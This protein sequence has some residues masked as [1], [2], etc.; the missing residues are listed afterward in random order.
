[1]SWLDTL[2]DIRKKD[3]S[4]S[5][6]ADRDKAARD[7]VNMASYGC[8]VVAVSPIPFSD[9]VLSLPMQSAMVMTVGHVYGRKV[10]QADAKDLILEL[11]AVAGMGMLARQG[12]KALLPVV[13]ALLTVP[14]AYAMNW[15]I[16][17][18]AME[19]FRSPEMPKEQLK[20]VY[21]AARDEGAKMFSKERF[22]A[23]RNSKQSQV[24]PADVG[25]DEAATQRPSSAKVSAAEKIVTQDFAA[26]LEKHP[27]VREAFA[28]LIHLDLSGE[29][30]GQWTVDLTKAEGFIS[31][32]LTGMPK[33]TVRCSGEDFTGLVKG[34]KNAQMAVLSGDLVLEPMD[35]ELIGT[36]GPLFG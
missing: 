16:G 30:G 15:A 31:S 11:G 12:I 29:G 33:L 5:P 6:E 20:K 28:G 21:E 3:F 26:R 32:G 35:L 17:R 23:F 14:A 10:T 1:M 13:G 4:T 9:A 25:S 34:R 19:Y 22:E 7:V 27:E 2:E 36:L 8:A 18:A 24:K